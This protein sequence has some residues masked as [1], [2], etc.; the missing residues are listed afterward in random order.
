MTC[1]YCGTRNGEGEHR[2]RR[3]GRRPG[4]SLTG[5][6]ALP[7]INGALAAQM[8]P[9]NASTTEH[10]VPRLH[11]QPAPKRAPGTAARRPAP[12]GSLAVQGTLFHDGQPSNVIPIVS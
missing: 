2:C 3:C 5:E 6:F 12:K 11:L 4:D 10:S 9:A 7:Q 8:Q 1:R